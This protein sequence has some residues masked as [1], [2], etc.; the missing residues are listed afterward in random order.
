MSKDGAGKAGVPFRCFLGMVALGE[1]PGISQI[2][3]LSRF[4]GGEG[5]GCFLIFAFLFEV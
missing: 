4:G 2:M 5:G 3:G 1:T